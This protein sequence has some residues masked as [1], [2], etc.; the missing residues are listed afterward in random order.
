LRKQG[1]SGTGLQQGTIVG[2]KVQKKEKPT[3]KVTAWCF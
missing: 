3:P 2:D 1:Y